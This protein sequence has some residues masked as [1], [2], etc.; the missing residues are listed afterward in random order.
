[1]FGKSAEFE[2]QRQQQQEEWRERE[3]GKKVYE[4]SEFHKET[5]M[6]INNEEKFAHKVLENK[7]RKALD[8]RM[9]IRWME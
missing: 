3:R 4:N 1:M 9:E 7:E 8:E 6:N 5:S 2:Q